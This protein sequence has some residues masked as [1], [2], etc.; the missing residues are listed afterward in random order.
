MKLNID[1]VRIIKHK[2]ISMQVV[3]VKEYAG[4][5]LNKDY[6]LKAVDFFLTALLKERDHKL[7][8]SML[9]NKHYDA[10]CNLLINTAESVLKIKTKIHALVNDKIITVQGS[11]IPKYCILDVNFE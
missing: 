3:D 8:Q 6:Q 9:R 1:S 10:N 4:M 11:S 7:F 5:D 2:K